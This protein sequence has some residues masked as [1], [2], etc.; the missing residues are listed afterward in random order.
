MTGRVTRS[1]SGYRWES[2]GPF[3]TK[4]GAWPP[5]PASA[6]AG[7]QVVTGALGIDEEWLGVVHAMAEGPQRRAI[8]APSECRSVASAAI[9]ND[10]KEP[11]PT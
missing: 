10:G 11:T 3:A 9:G 7:S 2:F 4:F 8:G 5:K 1:P 6:G